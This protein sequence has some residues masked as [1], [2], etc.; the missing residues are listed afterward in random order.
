MPLFM[1]PDGKLA[2]VAPYRRIMPYIMPTRSE[3]AV[4]FE[5]KLDLTKTREF[6]RAFNAS[7]ERRITVFHVFVW[8]IVRMLHQRPRLNR[9]VSGGR[10]YDREGIWISYS[11]KKSL[12]DEAPIVVPK[13]RFDP[14]LSFTELVEFV[15]QDVSRGRSD[16]KSHVDREL[17]LAL[18][19]PGPLLRLCVVLLRW[20]DAWNLLPGAFIRSDPMYASAFIA[21]LGSVRLD[22]AYHHLYEYGNIPLFA[23]IGRV[24]EEVVADGK[25]GVA[26]RHVASIKYT[27]DERIEDG[28]Y[29]AAA[30]DSL[31]QLIEDPAA[32]GALPS[33]PDAVQMAGAQALAAGT[34]DT[35]RAA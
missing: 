32:W 10:I 31:R 3:S 22:S 7:H 16:E 24:H 14:S 26:T 2:D 23:A 25:G 33:L 15:H 4:Y 11:A 13:R 27:L 19:L 1:R 20:L 18:R 17:S 12:D 34:Q 6:I 21:N 28:L 8:A 29:C 5:Q 30:V 9:F 35:V